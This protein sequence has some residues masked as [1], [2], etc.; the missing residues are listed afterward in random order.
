MNAISVLPPFSSFFDKTGKPLEAGYIYIGEEGKNAQVYPIAT[1]WD[2][3][4]TI[5]AVQ[6]IRT[7]GGYPSRNG[8]IATVYT[9]AR[10]SITVKNVGLQLVYSSMS[11][12][13]SLSADDV[14]TVLNVRDLLSGAHFAYTPVMTK[15]TVYAGQMVVT[16]EETFVY[17]VAPTASTDFDIISD[18]GVKFY[19]LPTWAD[20]RAEQFGVSYNNTAAQ[21]DAALIYAISWL[22]RDQNKALEFGAGQF[23]I[24]APLPPITVNGASIIGVSRESTILN[25]AT[26]TVSATFITVATGTGATVA[27]VRIE[28]LRLTVNNVTNA[29]GYAIVLDG[30]SDP[31]I[32][33][34]RIT[35]GLGFLDVGPNYKCNRLRVRNIRGDSFQDARNHIWGRFQ[36][37]ADLEFDQ[38][39][40]FGDGTTYRTSPF[41]EFRTIGSCDTLNWSKVTGRTDAGCRYGIFVNADNGT[42]VNASFSRNIYDKTGYFDGGSNGA[43]IWIEMTAASTATSGDFWK[44]QNID[45]DELRADTG[46]PL[47]GGQIVQINQG[48]STGFSAMRGITFRNVLWTVRDR[49][50]FKTA[51]TGTDIFDGVEVTGGL[52]RDADNTAIPTIFEIGSNRF[53]IESLSSG[54]AERKQNPTTGDFITITNPAVDEFSICNNMVYNRSGKFLVEPVY[55][56]PSAKR[57]VMGNTYGDG[58]RVI[59]QT[60]TG[61][62][63]ADLVIAAGVIT[64]THSYHAIDTEAAA[65]TDDLTSIE[66]GLDGQIIILRTV[67]DARVVTAKDGAAA[68]NTLALSGDFIMNS[69]RDRLMLQYDLSLLQWVELNRSNN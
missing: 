59:A 34:I 17:S 67:A 58:D 4:R 15:Q 33:D 50:I 35:R 38:V 41:W 6:P 51:H 37:Y 54:Y 60:I 64:A 55:T 22:N 31:Q 56:L 21:N 10:Y 9:A 69:V 53:T 13:I 8:S 27:T 3:A 5:A 49:A 30:V 39:K 36:R 47:A 42:F 65:A 57:R 46:G 16:Q 32:S 66:A 63:G 19:I 11:P 14:L 25:M 26:A 43:V 44:I 1:Y 52:I 7:T 29:S 62:R 24:A 2:E 20:A 12:T 48:A 45:F 28:S 40:I 23:E 18:D 68:A 61:N